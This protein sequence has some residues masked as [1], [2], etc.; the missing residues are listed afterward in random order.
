[1]LARPRPPA[2][3]LYGALIGH[4]ALSAGTYLIGKRALTELPALPLGLIRFSGASFFLALLLLRLK[5][6]GQRLPPKEVRRKLLLLAFIAVPIN[7]G[8]FL[9]GLQNSTPAH[10]A[11]LYALTPLFVLL[12]AQALLSEFPGWRTAT[13]TAMALGGTVFVLFEHGLDLSTGPLFGDLMLFI[14]VIAWSVY[15]AEGRELVSKYGALPTIAWTIIAGTILFFP[16]GLTAT[17]ISRERVL[18]ASPQ[19]WLGVVYLIIATSVISYLLWYWA[20]GHLAAARVAIFSNLQ[21]LATAILAHFFLG[22]RITPAFVGGAIVVIAGVLFA[23][24]GARHS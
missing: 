9:Y 3:L 20:L 16:V 11:L 17:W 19:A 12:L 10:A 8:F 4:T 22:D 1:M 5:P 2:A 18:H 14:A 21:P 23:Q 24:R 15:T 7:Q 6:R 13:G